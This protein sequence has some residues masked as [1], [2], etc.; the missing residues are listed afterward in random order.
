MSLRS[1]IEK[2]QFFRVRIVGRERRGERGGR[3]ERER[4]ER[5]ERGDARRRRK[6]ITNQGNP[7]L[8]M[9]AAGEVES[10][11]AR[12]DD[13]QA[14]AGR[15]S[16][17][18][19]I[20]LSSGPSKNPAP[21]RHYQENHAFLLRALCVAAA[22]LLFELLAA[23]WRRKASPNNSMRLVGLVRLCCFLLLVMCKSAAEET[24]AAKVHQKLCEKLDD[25]FKGCQS[26][27]NGVWI[28]LGGAT[29]VGFG[30][31]VSPPPATT[32][33]AAAVPDEDGS[34]RGGAA[35]TAAAD[36]NTAGC[37]A[38]KAPADHLLAVRGSAVH[39]NLWEK[40]TAQP[41]WML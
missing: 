20:S 10:V 40:T 2:R 14:D 3:A 24:L 22:A 12:G 28:R 23:R 37:V 35:A 17:H 38:S 6:R 25:S 7:A 33:A 8:E 21:P 31:T 27:V 19:R 36:G 11:S 30:L 13:E 41:P 1:Y 16:D 5:G 39:D 29:E 18:R 15:V 9:N 32:A 34:S 26:A 4:K